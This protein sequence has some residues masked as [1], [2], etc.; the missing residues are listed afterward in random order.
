MAN[1][2]LYYSWIGNDVKNGSDVLYTVYG[3]MIGDTL[4]N[5]ASVS[6]TN[7]RMSWETSY[8][9]WWFQPR[10]AVLWFV[11]ILVSNADSGSFQ[12]HPYLQYYDS[13]SWMWRSTWGHVDTWKWTT[14]T[15]QARKRLWTIWISWNNIR[16]SFWTQYRIYTTWYVWSYTGTD[17]VNSFTV[18]NLNVDD[19]IYHPWSMTVNGTNLVYVDTFWYKHIIAYDGNYSWSRPWTDHSWFIRLDPRTARRLYYVDEYWYVRRT[20][21]ASNWYNYTDWQWRNVGSSYRWYVWTWNASDVSAQRYLCFVNNS[22]Y[23]MRLMNW[24]PNW[25]E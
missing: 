18:T 3:N 7:F 5:I 19:T 23:A 12:V 20:Y 16:P 25:T 13:G 14:S 22:W 1:A 17:K 10:H 21:E 15:Y 8:D 11:A 2:V 6:Y 4:P 24:N 9:L